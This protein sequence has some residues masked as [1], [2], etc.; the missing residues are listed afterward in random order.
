MDEK[1]QEQK[2]QLDQYK[3]IMQ[4]TRTKKFE[5]S[6]RKLD[7]LNNQK[8]NYQFLTMKKIVDKGQRGENIAMQNLILSET[9]YSNHREKLIIQF[10]Q[11]NMGEEEK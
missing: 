4:D 11:M 1:Y 2:G 8:L 3:E 5:S 10:R 6:S 7:Q 9:G